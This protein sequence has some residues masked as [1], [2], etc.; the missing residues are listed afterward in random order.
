M[1]VLLLSCLLLPFSFIMVIHPQRI[2]G[3]KRF[4]VYSY[5]MML[6]MTSASL[7]TLATLWED[8][9]VGVL[10]PWVCLEVQSI[11]CNYL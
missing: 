6:L 5:F 10:W 11:L 8:V 2:S 9:H 4:C 3:R 7:G 1:M